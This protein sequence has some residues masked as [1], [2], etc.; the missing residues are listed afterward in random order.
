MASS[1]TTPARSKF[2]GFLTL[3]LLVVCIVLCVQMVR[4]TMAISAL[5]VKTNLNTANIET[6]ANYLGATQASAPAVKK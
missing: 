1:S 4:V 5:N 3:V 2:S 6:M